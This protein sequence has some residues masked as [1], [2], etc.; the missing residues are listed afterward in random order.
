MSETDILW[1][2]ASFGYALWTRTLKYPPIGQLLNRIQR[3]RWKREVMAVRRR[4]G[5]E[6]TEARKQL[7]IIIWGGRFKKRRKVGLLEHS[8]VY[9]VDLDD[10]KFEKQGAAR[11]TRRGD[12]ELEDPVSADCDYTRDGRRGVAHKTRVKRWALS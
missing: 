9:A 11:G 10:I 6:M 5:E 1:K 12:V 7:P 4:F 8:G 3:G 2:S